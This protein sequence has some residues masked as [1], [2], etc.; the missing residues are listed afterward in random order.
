MGCASSSDTSIAEEGKR[1][2]EE[3][4]ASSSIMNPLF[5][6]ILRHFPEKPVDLSRAG[7]PVTPNAISSQSTSLMGSPVMSKNDAHRTSA[8]EIPLLPLHAQSRF[9]ARPPDCPFATA[10]SGGRQHASVGER[11]AILEQELAVGLRRG[12]SKPTFGEGTL[13]P[14]PTSNWLRSL[15][16]PAFNNPS[17]PMTANCFAKSLK[18]IEDGPPLDIDSVAVAEQRIACTKRLLGNSMERARALIAADEVDTI[19]DVARRLQQSSCRMGWLKISAVLQLLEVVAMDYKALHNHTKIFLDSLIH[20]PGVHYL[21]EFAVDCG[22]EDAL[23]ALGE[24]DADVALALYVAARLRAELQ[25]C[26]LIA[27]QLLL[28]TTLQP[29]TPT[30]QFLGT[31]LQLSRRLQTV[32]DRVMAQAKRSSK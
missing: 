32:R 14:R 31:S 29:R 1:K 2:R 3:S 5:A 12:S 30:N 21:E 22:N 24:L 8:F 20:S 10:Y 25:Y 13:W 15:E 4:S 19:P 27:Q 7:S 28:A 11:R 26:C 6:D 17:N 16:A 18:H 9:V 23:Q